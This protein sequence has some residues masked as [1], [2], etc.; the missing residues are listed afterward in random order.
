[1]SS[2]STL[3]TFAL[4]PLLYIIISHFA[5]SVSATV[6]LS[7][8][9]EAPRLFALQS[10]YLTG[11]SSLK[12]H[13]SDP[14]QVTYVDF[15]EEE[16]ENLFPWSHRPVC[17]QY[18]D[19]LKSELCVYTNSSFS[20]GRGVSIFTTPS[21]A[22]EFAALQPFQD[23]TVLHRVNEDT[24]H[25]YTQEVLG[26]G[27]AMMAKT[28]LK[29]GDHL[30]AFSPVLI[31]NLQKILPVRENEMFLRRAIEQ[32]P[33]STRSAYLGLSR[34]YD[35]PDVKIQDILKSNAFE[36]QVGGMMH[37]AIFPEPARMNHDCAPK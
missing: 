13:T 8:S 1:M 9:N 33:P 19:D 16:S 12:S 25:W 10:C 35:N 2:I 15:D 32:L 30:T 7:C 5:S 22:H 31:V 21:I 4:F 3:P 28:K 6:P 18:F 14:Y 26:K 37:L 20:H 11:N 29:R 34:M 27:I 24:Q 17:T 23:S 36:I